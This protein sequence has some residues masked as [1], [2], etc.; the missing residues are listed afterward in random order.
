MS[1]TADRRFCP[2]LAAPL[3]RAALATPH[4]P[5][6]A[7]SPSSHARRPCSPRPPLRRSPPP[8][9]LLAH[10]PG[11]AHNHVHA[12][13]EPP[14]LASPAAANVARIIAL[15]T[16]KMDVQISTPGSNQVIICKLRDPSRMQ[17][18]A[19]FIATA[20]LASALSAMS[21]VTVTAFV[22]ADCTGSIL[23]VSNGAP[24]GE[25]QFLTL[26]GSSKSFGYSGVP[27]EILFYESGGEH[28]ACTNGASV[29]DSAGS[30]CANGPAGFNLESFVYS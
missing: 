18:N 28:D 15:F 16:K 2:D 6:A 13:P 9:S 26:G 1:L 21:Q 11:I 30:G 24:A 17:F 29:V 4:P 10:A 20:L 7:C 23:A 19:A 8:C 27:N 25:C 5:H 14:P 22:G 12:P 3:S